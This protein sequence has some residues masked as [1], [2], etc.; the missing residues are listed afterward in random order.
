MSFVP[1]SPIS[2][3]AQTGF[4][5]PTYT[6]VVDTPPSPNGKQYAITAV[7]GTQAN[8]DV[9][10]VSKPFTFTMFRP[11]QLK[12]LPAANPI[13]G[14]IKSVP[15]NSYK[16]VTRKGAMPGTNQV[17]LIVNVTTTIDVFAGQD[18]FEPEDVRAALSAHFGVLSANSSGIGDLVINGVL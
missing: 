18:T 8:V 4:T 14:V 9:H 3:T 6:F 2:G 12:A 15:K 13:T 5:S 1:S 16:L 11:A 7:G 17:P 10:T